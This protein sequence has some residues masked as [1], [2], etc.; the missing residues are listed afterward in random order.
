MSVTKVISASW[1]VA[2]PTLADV[3]PSFGE[4]CYFHFRAKGYSA[5]KLEAERSSETLVNVYQT[6]LCNLQENSNVIESK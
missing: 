4:A 2:P 1:K 3:Y 5:L 6:I